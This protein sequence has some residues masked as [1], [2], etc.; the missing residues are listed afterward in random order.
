MS[1]RWPQTARLDYRGAGYTFQMDY[2]RGP[3]TY[4]PIGVTTD[5]TPTFRWQA[6][7]SAV[8][9]DVWVDN[10]TTGVKQVIRLFVNH[11]QGAKEI[12]YTPTTSLP[13]AN[14]RW[15]VQAVGADGRRTGWSTAT[16]FN[17][18]VPSILAPRGS[19]NTNLPNFVWRRGYSVCEI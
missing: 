18:P 15:W 12:T 2:R 3:V 5:T 8:R 6:I 10:L 11:V 7:D 1:G 4:A 16:D 19:I 17:V 14:Y 9:Y 13:A